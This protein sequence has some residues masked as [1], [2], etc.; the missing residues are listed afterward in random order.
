M[1]IT[2]HGP[3][4]PV[5]GTSIGHPQPLLYPP[6]KRDPLTLLVASHS[7]TFGASQW[8]EILS[9]MRFHNNS[10]IFVQCVNRKLNH[11]VILIFSVATPWEKR[12]YVKGVLLK[13]EKSLKK[14]YLK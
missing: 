11:Q 7:S 5:G 3:T 12:K 1:S 10:D 9:K 6:K 13:V 8:D 4:S 14:S 2:V